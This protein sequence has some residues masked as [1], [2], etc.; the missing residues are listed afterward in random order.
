ML[1]DP[2]KNPA[3][4]L[5][6]AF[7]LPAWLTKDWI[8]NLTYQTAYDVCL[9]SNTPPKIYIRPNTLISNTQKISD[10]LTKNDILHEITPDNSAIMLN[11]PAAINSLPGLA[12]GLFTIQDIT[13]SLPVKALNPKP[14]ENILDLCA[15]P[16]TKTTQLAEL[17]NNT[18]SIT[19][20]DINK[21]RLPKLH[22]NI[23]RLKID[24]IKVVDYETLINLKQKFDVILIDAPCSNTGVLAK[25]TEARHNISQKF[26]RQLTQTQQNLLDIAAKMTKPNAK[27]CYSTCS[28]QKNENQDI[29]NAFLKNN[30]AFK[31]EEQKLSLPNAKNINS[32]GGFYAILTEQN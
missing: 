5:A 11:A 24:I 16:G 18:G 4:Y 25:R 20:T 2:Q 1:D 7:S 13:A 8:N 9:A 27:I 31:L 32:D 26:I 6:N 15:A 17:M 19:A 23:K 29:I 14:G 12:E 28:I 10:I 3:A 22:Q 30:P 21:K